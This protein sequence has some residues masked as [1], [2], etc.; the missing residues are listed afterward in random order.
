MRKKAF[1]AILGIMLI[2]IV[3][4][5]GVITFESWYTDFH[6]DITTDVEEK[7]I[8]NTIEKGVEIDT[9]IN[10]T[11]YIRNRGNENVSVNSVSLN[12]ID[13]QISQDIEPGLTNISLTNCMGNID[14]YKLNPV[15]VTDSDVL[16]TIVYDSS[17]EPLEYLSYTGIW[18]TH[19]GHTGSDSGRAFTLDNLDNTYING[20]YS[21]D[22]PLYNGIDL[23]NAGN[24]GLFMAKYNSSGNGSW[25]VTING[26][27]LYSVD[28]IAIDSANNVYMVGK[29]TGDPT[30]ANGID[31]PSAVNGDGFIIKYNSSGDGQWY[32]V[33][34]GT[35]DQYVR[36]IVV[37][38]NYNIYVVGFYHG[39]PTLSD[40]IDMPSTTN[41][42]IYII[43]YNSSGDGQWYNTIEGNS[44]LAFQSTD[45]DIDDN[46]NT[47]VLG[48]YYR[49]PQPSDGIDIPNS[50]GF[51]DLF[52]IKY[53]SS[54]DGQWVNQVGSNG[55]ESPG[56]VKVDNSNNVYIT[57]TYQND[58]VAQNGID[59]PNYQGAYDAFII[60]YDGDGNGIWSK[61]I[62]GTGSDYGVELAIDSNNNVFL[63]GFYQNDPIAQ[64]GID[65]PVSQ[66]NRDAYIVAY[67]GSSG[68]GILNLT[69]GGTE[70]EQITGLSI[71]S[72]DDILLGCYYYGDPPPNNGIDI[73][74]SSGQSD[75]CVAKYQKNN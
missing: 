33:I 7:G 4:I 54:G 14:S 39:D 60:K 19:I 53:N 65:L 44:S 35:E 66:G 13:C 29:Y 41:G 50:Q 11:L 21:F 61:T 27:D 30:A 59:L 63:G 58:P 24:T 31:L 17:Y 1:S 67:E 70:S 2:L 20:V 38:D 56:D 12:D 55:Y 37:D 16:D 32:K 3:I 57:G 34:S 48:Q 49:N 75:I 5:V 42:S 47:Y 6:I 18:S 23:P 8:K 22:P 28:G 10:G 52:L 68:R 74:A 69:F 15:I 25:A 72:N 40:G 71:D 9:I 62:G 43:K 73:P 45:L 46:Q 64:D 51:S 36:D 26:P